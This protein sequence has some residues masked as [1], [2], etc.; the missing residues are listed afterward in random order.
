MSFNDDTVT[1]KTNENNDLSTSYDT[2]LNSEEKYKIKGDDLPRKL[3]NEQEI[4]LKINNKNDNKIKRK[5]HFLY[6]NHIDNLYPKYLGRSRA[7]LYIKNYPLIIIGP[8]C[9]Y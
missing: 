8:D 2:D 4:S 5:N 3:Q 6:G 1:L 9:K 7:F